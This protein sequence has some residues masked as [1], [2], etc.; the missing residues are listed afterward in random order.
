M[1]VKVGTLAR[2]ITLAKRTIRM[3]GRNGSLLEYIKILINLKNARRLLL[4][5]QPFLFDVYRLK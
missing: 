1:V 4:K 3:V 2:E 5:N